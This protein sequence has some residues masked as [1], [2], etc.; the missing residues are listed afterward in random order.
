MP[1]FREYLASKKL[2]AVF[3]DIVDA[4]KFYT[5][6]MC[7]IREADTDNLERLQSVFPE[8]VEELKARYNAPGGALDNEELAWIMARER[9]Y[10][11]DDVEIV[12]SD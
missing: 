2:V 6:I 12:S 11:E 3:D 1:R 7:A 8:V 9:S 5:F 10:E 4:N